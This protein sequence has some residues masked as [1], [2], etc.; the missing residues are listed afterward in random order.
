MIWFTRI[1]LLVF[2]LSWTKTPAA[3]PANPLLSLAACMAVIDFEISSTQWALLNN[4]HS[5]SLTVKLIVL[6]NTQQVYATRIIPRLSDP[7]KQQLA[8]LYV[9]TRMAVF[10]T[11]HNAI[12]TEQLTQFHEQINQASQG[13]QALNT[14]I[15]Q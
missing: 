12:T 1:V 3:E 2:M 5:S 11:F 9:T 7:L 14:A 4:P 6:R 10:E 15:S 8:Q 13:C